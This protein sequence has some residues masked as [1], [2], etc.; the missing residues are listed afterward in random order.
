MTEFIRLNPKERVFLIQQAKVNSSRNYHE[1]ADILGVS[2]DM[3]FKYMRGDYLL[4]KRIFNILVELSKFKPENYQTIEREKYNRKTFRIPLLNEDI[5]EIFGVLNGDGYLSKIN[6]EIS[7]IG[8]VKTDNN[9]F[10]YL[11]K[12]FENVLGIKFK[13]EKFEHYLKLRAYSICLVNWLCNQH[14]FPKGKK[15]GKL[16]IPSVLLSNKKLLEAYIRG[17]FDTDGTFYLRRKDEPVIEI[18]S[19]DKK[20]LEQVRKQLLLLGFKGGI[21]EHRLFIYN[22][23]EIDQFFKKIK[24]SNPKHLNKYQKYLKLSVGGPMAKTSAFHD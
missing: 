4:P 23:H 1:F 8:N 5:A 13:I 16:K 9:Y 17:L 10:C 3:I 19:A 6:H 22:K 2:R 21:G 24:P 14:G 18:S 12:K 20:Y 11:K 15:K 7:V